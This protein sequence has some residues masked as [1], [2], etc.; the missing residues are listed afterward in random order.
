MKLAR[1]KLA[2]HVTLKEG[3][4]KQPDTEQLIMYVYK[5]DD[6]EFFYSMAKRMIELGIDPN[7]INAKVTK[8]ICPLRIK[9]MKDLFTKKTERTEQKKRH[10]NS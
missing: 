4:N 1:P 2:K 6:I 7:S 9:Y 10:I 3:E 5:V 8:H